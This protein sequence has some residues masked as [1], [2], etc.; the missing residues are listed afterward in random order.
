M[1]PQN[2][3]SLRQTLHITIPELRSLLRGL[4]WGLPVSLCYQAAQ[5]LA[6][7]I[8]STL[9]AYPELAFRARTRHVIT[10]QLSAI[11]DYHSPDTTTKQLIREDFAFNIKATRVN[12]A[13]AHGNSLCRYTAQMPVPIHPTSTA[14]IPRLPHSDEHSPK[15][16]Q[17]SPRPKSTQV[18]AS[19]VFRHTLICNTMSLSDLVDGDGLRFL[20]WRFRA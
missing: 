3:A 2:T 17:H 4:R 7:D 20:R 13:L 14:F 10:P 18:L 15:H 16:I 8:F 6:D 19:S 5:P 11:V 1:T 12:R 9:C